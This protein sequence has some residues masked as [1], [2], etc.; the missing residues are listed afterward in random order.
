[1]AMRAIPGSTEYTYSVDLEQV[2]ETKR[3]IH[4]ACGMLVS[5]LSDARWLEDL[6]QVFVD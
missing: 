3:Q 4:E 6:I 2:S 1:M 5:T